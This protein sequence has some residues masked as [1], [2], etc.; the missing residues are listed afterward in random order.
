[1]NKAD[2]G[3][4]VTRL[5]WGGGVYLRGRW[6]LAYSLTQTRWKD[7]GRRLQAEQSSLS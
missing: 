1:M 7:T 6:W 3:D 4:R 2:T 5:W